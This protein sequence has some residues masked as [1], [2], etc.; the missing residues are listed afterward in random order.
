VFGPNVLRRGKTGNSLEEMA[1]NADVVAV[2]KDL[3]DF[4]AAVFRVGAVITGFTYRR[5]LHIGDYYCI[6]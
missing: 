6:D 4:H 2:V 1:Q 3:I 5:L